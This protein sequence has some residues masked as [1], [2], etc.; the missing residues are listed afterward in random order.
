MRPA[1]ILALTLV[2]IVQA[3]ALA[4]ASPPAGPSL[5]S[6]IVRYAGGA[7]SLDARVAWGEGE[8]QRFES[9]RVVW[10]GYSIRVLMDE[11]EMIGSYSERRGLDSLTVAEVLA[12]KRQ[13]AVL[14]SSG[15]TVRRTAKEVLE[16]LEKGRADKKI[17]KDVA[18]FCRYEVGKPPS[19][20]AVRM[21]NLDLAF[22]FE[23]RPL[24][25][26]GEATGEESLGLVSR[27]FD[28]NHGDKAREGLLAAAGIHGQAA[29]AIPFLEKVLTGQ[30]S[31]H[32]RKE[33]AFWIGQQHAESGLRI[34][35]RVAQSDKSK[36]VR[37]G[38]VFAISQ[39]SLP[40]AVDELISLARGAEQADVRKQSVFWLGQMASK[41][42]GAALEDFA[43]N[44]G[45]LEIQEQAVFA[46]SELPD[47]QGVEPLI[48]LA[49]THP[50]PRVRKKAIFWLGECK[51]PRALETLVDIL[52]GK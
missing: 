4:A 32:L 44:G 10:V 21:S 1:R 41:K 49:K 26:L 25:W 17:P 5:P 9:G 22:D 24:I 33:A 50:D 52:K 48:K 11:N 27:L 7:S 2:A 15:E 36:E 39:V 38:C 30:D 37:E 35:V 23:D 29:L 51:D 46:L 45:N 34:L 43:R 14:P 3:A 19:L 12:G 18:I 13:V 47:N 42:A 8:V 20:S 31:E 16:K 6:E 28:E 40:Q